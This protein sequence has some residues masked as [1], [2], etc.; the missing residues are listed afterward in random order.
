MGTDLHAVT[1]KIS[2]WDNTIDPLP[3]LYIKKIMENGHV[4]ET[5][6]KFPYARERG[7]PGDCTLLR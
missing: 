6:E 4:G 2:C 3:N 1:V 5:L 7:T